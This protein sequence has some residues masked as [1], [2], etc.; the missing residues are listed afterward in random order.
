MSDGASLLTWSTMESAPKDRDILVCWGTVASGAMGYDIV[1]HW[2]DDMWKSVIC[3][4]RYP[5]DA[6]HLQGWMNL[7][8]LPTADRVLHC[9][10]CGGVMRGHEDESITHCRWCVAGWEVCDDDHHTMM[11]AARIQQS[12][13]Q[14]TGSNIDKPVASDCSKEGAE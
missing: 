11:N 10:K 2:Y 9:E 3:S 14:N 7:P 6:F 5:A 8:P 4:D 1:H 12:L 13:M